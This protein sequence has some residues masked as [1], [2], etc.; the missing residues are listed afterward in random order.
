[1]KTTEASEL[2]LNGARVGSIGK[3]GKIMAKRKILLCLAHMSGNEMK[4]IED[5]MAESWVVPLGPNV[6]GFEADLEQ[7]V[8]QDKRVVAL[9]AGTAALHLA[10]VALGVGVGDEVICQSFTF[11]ASSN[12]VVYQGATPVFVDSEPD[13]W[14]MDPGL[15]DKAIADRIAE[16]GR[17]PKAIIPVYLYGMPAKLR[18]IMAVAKKYDIP[19][20]EDSAEGFGSRYC[21]QVCGTFGTYGVLSFNG[22]KMITT[23]GGGALICPDENSKE[24]VM[25]Y[26]TQARESYP[27]YE[28]EHIGYNYRMSNISAGI[29]RGQMTILEEHIRHHHHIAA[30]YKEAFKDFEGI[31]FHENPSPEFDSNYWLCTILLSP[32]LKVKGQENV[33]QK[34][35][36]AAIGGAGSVVHIAKS[37][38]TRVEPD[39]NVE[40][41]R[42]ALVSVGIESRPLWKPMHL[43]PVYAS[44]PAYING[45]SESLFK[46]GLCLPSGPW[47][48]DEDVA[49]II[50]TIKDNVVR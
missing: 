21:S 24:R 18:E 6:N 48:T 20:V 41:M 28:H 2:K 30:L 1:M 3:T 29:G 44:S 32:D 15:L 40:A 39:A 42:V 14:N 13:T 25:F 17:K 33:Y 5:A 37:P 23:S 8:G 11:C 47:V 26:A 49:F 43:Q 27:Y 9:S 7:Y 38:H 34:V 10:L 31:S 19:V 45:V 36:G 22:N 46:R 35:E 4:F 16:T 50:Q 12:P